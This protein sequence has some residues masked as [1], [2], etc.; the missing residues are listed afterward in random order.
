MSLKC[1]HWGISRGSDWLSHNTPRMDSDSKS[2]QS[3]MAVSSCPGRQDGKHVAIWY[4]KKGG[5]LYYNHKGFHPIVLLGLVD[6]DYKFIW[7]DMG[8]N[9][10]VSDTQIFTDSELKEARENNVIGFPNDDRNTLTLLWEMMPSVLR[11]GWWSHMEGLPVA[12]RIFN[13]QFSRAMRIVNN[14]F[15]ILA[16]KF[17]L[18]L[19]QPKTATSGVDRRYPVFITWCA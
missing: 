2:V 4:P 18:P 5:S 16:N 6:V 1:T 3:E 12:E 9:C 13:Y 19:N 10:A 14:A 11:H 15:R 17:W 8:S 7:A